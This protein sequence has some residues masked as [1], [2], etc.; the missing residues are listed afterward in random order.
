MA[1]NWKEKDKKYKQAQKERGFIQKHPWIPEDKAAELEN[2]T[3]EWRRKHL[4]KQINLGA[5]V[6][7]Q[8]E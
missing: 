2:I 8:V 6:Q 5:F 1:I 3:H 4:E 7:D